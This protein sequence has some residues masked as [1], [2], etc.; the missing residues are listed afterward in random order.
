MEQ[1]TEQAKEQKNKRNKLDSQWFNRI[2]KKCEKVGISQTIIQRFADYYLP[3]RRDMDAKPAS[4]SSRVKS[5]SPIE[6]VIMVEPIDDNSSGEPELSYQLQ[7]DLET[8]D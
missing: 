8:D 3:G 2:L 1:N 6:P 5:T 4:S 7:L